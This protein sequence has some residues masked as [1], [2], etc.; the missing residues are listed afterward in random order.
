MNV[1]FL[2]IVPKADL[3]L[4]LADEFKK[5]G[6]AVTFVTPT[7]QDTHFDSLSGHRILFFHAGKMLNVSIP[8]KAFSNL[9]FPNY[10]LRAVKK[11]LNPKDYHL[12]LMSTPPLGYLPS[13]RF[14]KKNNP[15]IKFYEI[16]RDIHPEAAKFILDKIPGSFPFFKKKAQEIYDLADVVGCM[17]P[18]DVELVKTNYK[19]QNDKKIQL[20]PNWGRV[21]SYQEPAEEIK[22]KYGLAGKFMIIYGGNMG[23]GQNLPLYLK[24]AKEKQHLKDVLF[25]FI[26][27]GTEREKLRE[28]VR[29]EHITNVRI[30]NT[31]PHEDYL[32]ILRCASLGIITLGPPQF[33]ANCPSKAVTYWQNKI[34]IISTL[35]RITDFGS[36][37]IDRSECGL[38]SYYD[39]IDTLSANFDTLYYNDELR[40][41]MGMNG[42]NFF[43]E[44]FTV[45]KTYKKIM[46]S[47]GY[48]L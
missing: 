24:L 17:S 39:D 8:R 21:S 44:N 38:W 15:D 5:N 35:D 11:H 18:F 7:E 37:F 27:N 12:I 4:S 13:I 40:N 25:F 19:H 42:Y 16:L 3:Y 22:K 1:L 30:E 36:Y 26:G 20:L 29:K 9:L 45:D 46:E 32:H 47:L 6:H 41:W 2:T 33:F 23:I 28:I 34:P 31:I 10:C 14:L 48:T 43:M